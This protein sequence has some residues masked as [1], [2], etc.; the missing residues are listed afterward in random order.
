LTTAVSGPVCEKPEKGKDAGCYSDFSLS[1]PALC[2]M[3]E[4]CEGFGTGIG[5]FAEVR[6]FLEEMASGF[7]KITG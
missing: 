3:K 7:E 5:V 1:L 4:V 2:M 6:P